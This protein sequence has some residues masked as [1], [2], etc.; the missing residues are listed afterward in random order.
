MNADERASTSRKET[1]RK[2]G[3]F[4]CLKLHMKER[5]RGQCE[6]TQYMSIF[7][8]DGTTEHRKSL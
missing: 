7:E 2:K 5:M 6:H 1:F 8:R 3:V 4:W